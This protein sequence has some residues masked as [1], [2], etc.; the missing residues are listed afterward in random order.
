MHVAPD[1]SPFE[2]S[3][4]SRPTYSVQ[5]FKCTQFGEILLK[6]IHSI[7]GIKSAFQIELEKWVQIVKSDKAARLDSWF[8]HFRSF[9]ACS[10]TAFS[11][12]V[13]TSESNQSDFWTRRKQLNLIKLIVWIKPIIWIEF[14]LIFTCKL[15]GHHTLTVS[16]PLNT[17]LFKPSYL[18]FF[19]IGRFLVAGLH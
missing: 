19:S 9:Y 10:G 3:L 13:P 5:L 14:C 12:S 8:R 15:Y 2:F 4:L 7:T 11:K 1:F 18:A 16:C 17:T 6:A